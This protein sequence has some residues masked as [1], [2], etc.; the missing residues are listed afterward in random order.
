[1]SNL[2]FVLPFLFLSTWNFSEKWTFF[3]QGGNDFNIYVMHCY[4]YFCDQLLS[5]TSDH[6]SLT[7]FSQI[8][9]CNKQSW[10]VCCFQKMSTELVGMQIIGHLNYRIK[11]EIRHILVSCQWKGF[12]SF[13]KPYNLPR[14]FTCIINVLQ[15]FQSAIHV[16]QWIFR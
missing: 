16:V 4:L 6:F 5:P 8:H 2:G 13:F 3:K 15:S 1:M 7:G 11:A 14:W 12:K 10:T 9:N